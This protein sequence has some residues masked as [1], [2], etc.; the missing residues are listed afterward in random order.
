M[1]LWALLV[2]YALAASMWSVWL[3]MQGLRQ[4]PAPRAGVF[5]VLL[6]V[7]AAAVG[8]LWL[9]EPFGVGH[10]VAF[11]LALAGLLLAVWPVRDYPMTKG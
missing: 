10:A 11:A 2:F 8:V 7:G 5:T 9:G 6:P 1:D 4:V 3:W